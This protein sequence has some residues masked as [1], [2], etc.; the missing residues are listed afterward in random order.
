M[1]IET[2]SASRLVVR[3]IGQLWPLRQVRWG[4]SMVIVAQG[5]FVCLETFVGEY[6][7][8]SQVLT[9]DFL[10]DKRVRSVPRHDA[11]PSQF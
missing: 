9:P 2:A 8:A 1:F 4:C 7:Y 3:V 5:G 11:T 10:I 6:I